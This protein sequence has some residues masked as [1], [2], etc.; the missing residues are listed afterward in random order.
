VARVDAPARALRAH[1]GLTE[2]AA[3]PDG[4]AS[5]PDTLPRVGAR[6]RTWHWLA[7]LTAAAA[8]LR[9]TSLGVQSFTTDEAFTVQI[10]RHSFGGILSAVSHTESTPPLYYYL[11]WAWRHVS[12][13][14]E[15]GMRSLPALFG[16]ATIP[17]SYAA[18]RE[19]FSRRV[20]LLCAALVTFSP[21][22]I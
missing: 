12:G 3:R 4:A 13:T 16:T 18:G 8:A 22:L 20:G 10:A 2:S 19:L 14:G 1:G 5:G 11:A 9:F 6:V 21:L 17:A 7:L 15:A